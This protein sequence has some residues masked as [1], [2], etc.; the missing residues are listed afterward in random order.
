MSKI[1]LEFDAIEEADQARW[2]L[3]GVKWMGAMWELDQ[4]LRS[5]TKHGA[6]L[7]RNGEACDVEFEVVSKVREMMRE[8]MVDNNLSFE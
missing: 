2:A 5:T 6:S 3:D 8:I 7:L 1:I 4:A